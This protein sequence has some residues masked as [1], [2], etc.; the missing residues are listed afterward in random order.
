MIARLNTIDFVVWIGL[1]AFLILVTLR[2]AFKNQSNGEAYFM[3]DRSLRWWS[4]AGSIYGTNVSLVQIIGMLGIGYSI[5]FAQSHYEILAIPAILLL[6]FVFVP[7]YRKQQYFTL[8]EYLGK[9]YDE[10]VQLLYTVLILVV[11]FLLMVGG[12]YIGARQL[13]LLFQ[14][15]NLALSYTQNI[16]VIAVISFSLVY[17]G[18]MS[19][20]VVAENIV[21]ILIV[22]AALLVGFY[23]FAQPEIGG[24]MGLLSKDAALPYELQK[25]KL[26]L[27][28]NHPDL[29]CTG[30]FTGLLILHCFFWTTNQFE[31]QRV[32]A[33]ASDR[34]AKIGVLVAG[35]LKLTIPFFTIAA[36]VAAAILFRTRFDIEKIKPDDAFMRLVE[37]VIPSGNGLLGL[38]LA[39]FSVAI[40]SSIY[41]MLN[42]ASTLVTFDLYKKYIAPNASETAL[43]KMGRWTVGFL[44]ISA[45]LAAIFTFDPASDGNFFLMLSKNTSYFKPGIVAVFFLGI[46]WKKSH[47]KAALWAI[48]AAIPFGLCLEWF[49]SAYL[50][51]IQWI[52]SNFGEKLNFLHRIFLTFLASV[53]LLILLS[54]RWHEKGKVTNQ[55]DLMAVDLKGIL[56]HICLF[57]VL[58]LSL[59]LL[60]YFEI[61]TAKNLAWVAAFFVLLQFLFAKKILAEYFLGGI[62][63]ALVVWVLFWFR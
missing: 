11:I 37:T 49:Y 3:A 21:T 1:I 44:C 8:S 28:S 15:S 33:A 63:S 4:V 46:F 43:V 55:I 50:I 36:G 48:F 29:P 12:F 20:V 58:Q 47:P 31:V 53:L 16:G 61:F 41:S 14:G 23:T 24:F 26:Y 35:L 34:D 38:I 39:G 17:F 32:L 13:G 25:I 18:G 27:P 59:L 22:M 52:K 30:V 2:T 56:K 62:L 40:F 57:L 19:A 5:G 42:S 51:D 60:I 9:R 6:A 10:R 54:K 45:A 7:I